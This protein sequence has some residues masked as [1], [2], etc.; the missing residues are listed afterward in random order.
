VEIK[1]Y[2]YIAHKVIPRPW[3]VECRFTVSRLT[4]D[5]HINDIAML[6]TGK[7]DENEI[8]LAIENRLSRIDIPVEY[9]EPERI[10]T[11]TEI[12]SLLVEKGYLQKTEKIEDL[13]VLSELTAEEVKL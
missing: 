6:E 12:K 10:Y 1:G 7:E 4:D 9:K 13:K 8:A 3:G 11:E 5:S 2:K